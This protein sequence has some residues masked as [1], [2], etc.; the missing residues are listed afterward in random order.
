MDEAGDE[1]WLEVMGLLGDML[2]HE[3]EDRPTMALAHERMGRCLVDLT[4]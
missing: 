1:R 2:A 4:S 3:Q